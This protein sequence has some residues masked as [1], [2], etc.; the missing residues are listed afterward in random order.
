MGENF[1]QITGGQKPGDRVWE[2]F[3][4]FTPEWQYGGLKRAPG[5]RMMFS[6]RKILSLGSVLGR[7][8]DGE[9]LTGTE[10]YNRHFTKRKFREVLKPGLAAMLVIISYPVF[11]RAQKNKLPRSRIHNN[12]GIRMNRIRVTFKWR[13]MAVKKTSPPVI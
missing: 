3:G 10:I 6:E 7:R 13:E 8:Q 1:T 2:K 12:S 4:S 5:G 9:C 11:Y